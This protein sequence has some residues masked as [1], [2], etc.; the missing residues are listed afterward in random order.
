[1]KIDNVLNLE[2]IF[3]QI[4]EYWQPHFISS[5]QFGFRFVKVDGDYG[6][7]NHLETDKVIFV[8]YGN[9]HIDFRS[10][11]KVSIH[12]GEIYVVPKG[13]EHKPHAC[14]ESHIVIIEIS[15][16]EK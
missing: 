3:S 4:K 16:E 11:E 1:M 15:Q 6:W 10:Q 14:S 13:I 2:N 5:H 7:H 12:Q 8:L 9:L